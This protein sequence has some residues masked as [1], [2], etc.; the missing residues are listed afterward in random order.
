MIASGRA[1]SPLIASALCAAVL[2][3]C[4][5]HKAAMPLPAGLR[6]AL[7]Q[8]GAVA[9][10]LDGRQPEHP[11][12]APEPTALLREAAQL[13]EASDDL[14]TDDLLFLMSSPALIAVDTA[15]RDEVRARLD[16]RYALVGEI[17]AAPV[18]GQFFVSPVIVIPTPGY[19][20][21]FSFPLRLSADPD[22]LRARRLLRV[23]DLDTGALLAES[24][25]ILR[26]D[27]EDASFSAKSIKMGLT[28]MGIPL[29]E[30]N[31]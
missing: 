25:E 31:S 4:S 23:V 22:A 18:L 27:P 12:H 26:D 9:G 13:R 29:Q 5:H 24:V 3:G 15:R 2:G 6:G 28:E 8:D 7:L 19:V 16:A 10:V 30:R 1:L 14:S 11:A 20:A 17:G 21:W